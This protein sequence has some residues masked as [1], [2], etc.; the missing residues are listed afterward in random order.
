[1][2]FSSIDKVTDSHRDL[3]LG[4]AVELPGTT[5]IL[6]YDTKFN[7]ICVTEQHQGTCLATGTQLFILLNHPW[8]ISVPC[9]LPFPKQ[10]VATGQKSEWPEDRSQQAASKCHR[11]VLGRRS[12]T[13]RTQAVPCQLASE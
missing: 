4:K 10:R 9:T 12:W 8:R 6:E 7:Y 11:P 1:M 5:G 13:A 2:Y 3:T